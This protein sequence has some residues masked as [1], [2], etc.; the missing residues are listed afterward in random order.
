MNRQLILTN[1]KRKIRAYLDI[2]QDIARISPEKYRK[3]LS[4][5][6][7]DIDYFKRKI[8][9]GLDFD[10][11]EKNVELVRANANAPILSIPVYIEQLLNLL[12]SESLIKD[13]DEKLNIQLI[14][15]KLRTDIYRKLFYF[16][17]DINQRKEILETVLKDFAKWKEIQDEIKGS[18]TEL[19]EPRLNA[20]FLLVEYCSLITEKEEI[21]KYATKAETFFNECLTIQE[22]E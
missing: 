5:V 17:L 19:C 21:Q 13:K 2:L 1:H 6:D 10:K 14:S 20:G 9:P 12:E 7:I 18:S 11:F 22:E 8:K 15:L 16:S 4:N 3:E